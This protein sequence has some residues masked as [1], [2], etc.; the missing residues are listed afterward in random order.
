ML[1]RSL[2]W[3]AVL[4]LLYIATNDDYP[5]TLTG[6]ASATPIAALNALFSVP[7]IYMVQRQIVSQPAFASLIVLLS[8]LLPFGPVVLGSWGAYV[9]A[10]D[11][12]AINEEAGLVPASILRIANHPWLIT[13][14]LIAAMVLVIE[15]G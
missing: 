2:V 15:E 3:W 5:A 14:A 11:V 8:A 9:W 10:R 4:L 12:R 6:F 7:A 1:F 13:A